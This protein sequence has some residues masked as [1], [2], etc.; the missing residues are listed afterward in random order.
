MCAYILVHLVTLNEH[1]PTISV[2]HNAH[3]QTHK[4][5][6]QR[7]NYAFVISGHHQ[8]NL[9]NEILM[10]RT[11][12]FHLVITANNFKEMWF[13]VNFFDRA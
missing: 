7:T 13:K 4:H 8:Q 3:K 2:A 1:L 11:K 5:N 6:Q 12:D 10:F 9:S